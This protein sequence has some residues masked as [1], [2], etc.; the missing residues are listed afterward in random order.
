[1]EAAIRRRQWTFF[2][3]ESLAIQPHLYCSML[4]LL[5]ALSRTFKTKQYNSCE[6]ALSKEKTT[7]SEESQNKLRK[8][9]RRTP[10]DAYGGFGPSAASWCFEVRKCACGIGMY[11]TRDIECGSIIIDREDPIVSTHRNTTSTAQAGDYYSNGKRFCHFCVTPLGNLQDHVNFLTRGSDDGLSKYLDDNA[12]LQFTTK[13]PSL[14]CND[15]QQVAWCSQQCA[16]AGQ[17]RHRLLC[18]RKN[19]KK[20][21]N[22]E[23]Q[24]PLQAFYNSVENPAI[25]QLAVD[26]IAA[27]LVAAEVELGKQS[28]KTKGPKKSDALTDPS[29][30]HFWEDYGSHPLWWEVGNATN[31]EERKSQCQEFTNLLSRDVFILRPSLQSRNI[32]SLIESIKTKICNLENI[33]KLLGMFQCNVMEFEYLSPLEQYWNH[34]QQEIEEDD[35][36]KD[37]E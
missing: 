33:G 26:G 31:F 9:K 8:R 36:K 11:A 6:G 34:L 23:Q 27:I 19:G 29:I 20:K 21:Q 17:P 22:I 16:E 30:F 35:D 1:M 28:M 5:P 37:Q 13:E 18:R 24:T 2:F 10:E 14:E 4:P 25:F 7:G 12:G 32:S 3:F 15:C